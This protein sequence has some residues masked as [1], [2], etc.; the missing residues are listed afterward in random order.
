MDDDSKGFKYWFFA[1]L[2]LGTGLW[3]VTL[4]VS[5]LLLLASNVADQ[6]W[7]SQITAVTQQAE[8]DVLREASRLKPAST[9]IVTVPPRTAAQCLKETGGVVNEQYQQC[10]MGYSYKATDTGTGSKQ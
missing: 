8:R 1:G 4:I 5:I 6:Y 3:V 10:R 9:H 2:G 7:L